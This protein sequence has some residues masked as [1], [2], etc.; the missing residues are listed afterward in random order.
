MFVG[1]WSNEREQAVY[2]TP[3]FPWV[4]IVFVIILLLVSLF[5]MCAMVYGSCTWY[6]DKLVM[7]KK[8]Q[9]G[10]DSREIPP[11]V[12]LNTAQPQ[13][14][15]ELKQVSLHTEDYLDSDLD[16]CQGKVLLRTH[17]NSS[18]SS[19]DSGVSSQAPDSPIRQ[20]GVPSV[21]SGYISMGAPSAP[22]SPVSVL[23]KE[24]MLGSSP[25][26]VSD[27]GYSRVGQMDTS[28]SSSYVPFT[29]I[30]PVQSHSSPGYIS[31]GQVSEL[32][33]HPDH[34]P[35]AYSR[36]G[37]MEHGSKHRLDLGIAGVARLENDLQVTSEDSS[38]AEKLARINIDNKMVTFSR[39]NRDFTFV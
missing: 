24:P 21:V 2:C 7:I 16:D 17:K 33:F 4:L 39:E 18:S 23:G 28:S 38:K 9:G 3:P 10:L 13:A 19:Q 14:E 22:Q 29:A 20:S 15:Y 34:V 30:R 26:G 32:V 27:L 35:A 6:S 37:V 36:V 1:P 11:V 8:I 5:C 12:G 31:L 25:Q